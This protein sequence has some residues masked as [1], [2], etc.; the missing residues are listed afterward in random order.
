[1]KKKNRFAGILCIGNSQSAAIEAFRS[2][3]CGQDASMYTSESGTV[4]A[5]TANAD[6]YDPKTGSDLLSESEELT[7]K[8][9]F[10]SNSSVASATARYTICLDGCMTHIVSE[11]KVVDSCPQCAASLSEVTEERIEEHALQTSASSL[12]RE[13]GIVLVASSISAAMTAMRDTLVS[14]EVAGYAHSTS[15]SSFVAPEKVKFDP[16]TGMPV[17]SVSSEEGSSFV[18]SVSASSENPED[19]V[20]HVYSCSANCENNVTISTDEEPVFCAHCSAPLVDE[21]AEEDE[22][23]SKTFE[24][25]ED[26]ME[27]EL[28]SESGEDEDE[29]FGED[30]DD[31]DEDDAMFDEDDL[32]DLDSESCDFVAQSNADDEDDEDD[33]GEDEDEEDFEDDLDD[34]D[35]GDLDEDEDDLDDEDEDDMDSESFSI[36]SLSAIASKTTLD[37]SQL[38]FARAQ[39]TLPTVHMFYNGSPIASA[40]FNSV[41]NAIGEESARKVFNEEVFIRAVSAAAHEAGVEA[42]IAQYGFN[43]HVVE[44]SISTVLARRYEEQYDRRAAEIGQTIQENNDKYKERFVA[45]LSTSL[46]GISKRFWNDSRNPVVESLCSNLASAGIANPRPIVE[47]AFVTNANPLLGDAVRRAQLLMTKSEVAQ[48]EIAEAVAQ[49][50]GVT[51]Q[52]HDAPQEPQEPVK[53]VSSAAPAASDFDAK[54]ARAFAPRGVR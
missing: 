45:A 42:A 54:L 52:E 36:S 53:S 51:A 5:S 24:E 25:A 15:S 49:A 2:V 29:D 48:N 50:A 37:P 4:Y 16:Y 10:V 23:E 44:A 34:L 6:L 17:T 33:F 27:D 12:H 20:V 26:E 39:G 3:A 8:A 43:P 21:E 47:R 9:E 14:G 40:S 46:L 31:F 22:T 35:D 7:A 11:S 13:G 38:S 19:V 28:S 1:M 41:S 18:A 32:D 30:E